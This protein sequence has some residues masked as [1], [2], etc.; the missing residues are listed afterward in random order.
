MIL[1]G[2]ALIVIDAGRG[3]TPA[4]PDA[5][6][7]RGDVVKVRRRKSLSHFPVEAVIAVAIPPG[8]S[9]DY[10]L[11]DLVGESRPLMIRAGRRTITYILVNDGDPKPYLARERDLI[12]TEK[13]VEIGTVRRETLSEATARGFK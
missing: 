9:P 8:F 2:N 4:C 11:A 13:K 5:R 6:F 3:E 7:S 10:A 12:A 1:N